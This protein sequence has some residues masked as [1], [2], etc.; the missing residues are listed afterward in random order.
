MTPGGKPVIDVPGET[1]TSPL[2]IV[3]PVLVTADPPNTPNDAAVPR[4]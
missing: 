1:P 4:S 2:T 3:A